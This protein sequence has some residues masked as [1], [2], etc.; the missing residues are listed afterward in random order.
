MS[1]LDIEIIKCEYEVDELNRFRLPPVVGLSCFLID[2]LFEMFNSYY[3]FVYIMNI[4]K[5]KV[6]HIE[7]QLLLFESV[8]LF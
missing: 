4:H 3:C 7:S 1:C 2:V 5:L 8:A 6:K